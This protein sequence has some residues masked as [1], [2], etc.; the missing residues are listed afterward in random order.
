M[1]PGDLVTLGEGARI[2]LYNR[3]AAWPLW[4]DRDSWT[5]SLVAGHISTGELAV[6]LRRADDRVE[7]LTGKGAKG[8]IWSGALSVVGEGSH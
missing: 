8:W 3:P 6:V 1:K 2:G 5:T 4:G 7:L